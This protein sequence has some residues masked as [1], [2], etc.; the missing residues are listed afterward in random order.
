MAKIVVLGAGSWGTA[1]A[2]VLSQNGHHTI[3]WGRNQEQIAQMSQERINQRYLPNV[4]L[5]E[6]MEFTSDF[7]DLAQADYVIVSVPAQSQREL[8]EQY[9]QFFYNTKAILVNVSK[10]IEI[11]SGKCIHEI[12]EELLGIHGKRFVVLS[13]PSHAEEFGKNM[14]TA[15]VAASEDAEAALAV[16][17]IFM[18]DAVRVYTTDDVIGVEL[19]GALKNIIALAVGMTVGLAY[20][21]NAKAAL[22]TR[23][24]TEI[25]RLGVALGAQPYTFLGLTGV[26]DLIV[27]CTSMHSRNFRAGLL[28]GQGKP[29]NQVLQEMGM[30]VEGVMTTEAAY[31]LAQE[32][33]IEMPIL[34]KMYQVIFEGADVHISAQNLMT[35]E[36]KSETEEYFRTIL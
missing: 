22:M 30:V 4:L 32:K 21:D 18:N 3:L 1:I 6:Q 24:L 10:G 13:G 28:L 15:L 25:T 14:P 26:G 9:R 17:E 5:D 27:T 7:P 8:L 23:G 36:K 16:Q 34:E 35:R 11:S 33:N 12:Y 29:L 2:Q 31:R 19:G 20:G